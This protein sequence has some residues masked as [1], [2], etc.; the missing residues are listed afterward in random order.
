MQQK[1]ALRCRNSMCLNFECKYN[2]TNATDGILTSSKELCND[3]NI[4]LGDKKICLK[5]NKAK[6]FSEFG[7][8]NG[9]KK[10]RTECKECNKIR[11]KE[12]QLKNK[13]YT[14]QPPVLDEEAYKLFHKLAKP[15]SLHKEVR[16]C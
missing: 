7:T 1:T 12:W 8:F 2:Q 15:G 4:I 3:K 14:R 11:S 10:L 6:D 16:Y 13:T 5:C 9:T